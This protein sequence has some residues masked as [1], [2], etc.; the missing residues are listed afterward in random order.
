MVKS[1]SA[2]KVQSI[3]E[4]VPVEDIINTAEAIAPLIPAIGPALAI[5]VKILRVILAVQPAASKAAGAVAQQGENDIQA[6]RNTFDRMWE[7]AMSDD[8]MTQEEKDFLRPYALAAGISETEFELMI[9]NK[10]NI[11]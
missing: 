1:E 10:N 4:S 6:K 2:R 11:H 8:T 5:I 7:I 3:I 9:L